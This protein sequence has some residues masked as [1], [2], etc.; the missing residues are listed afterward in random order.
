MSNGISV[1]QWQ[2]NQRAKKVKLTRNKANELVGSWMQSWP[3]MK[4]T[5]SEKMHIVV[6]EERK[7][8]IWPQFHVGI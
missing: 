4:I 6:N 5:H 1:Q 7:T 3:T 8:P 2:R